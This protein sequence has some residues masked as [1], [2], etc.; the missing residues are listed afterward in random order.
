VFSNH[1]DA[2]N[3]ER[4]LVPHAGERINFSVAITT[5]A[6]ARITDITDNSEDSDV[7]DEDACDVGNVPEEG[8]SDRHAW[9]LHEIE[10]GKRVKASDIA[11]YFAV[12]TKTAERDLGSP[13]DQGKIEFSGSTR[14][15]YYRLVAD[16]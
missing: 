5:I 8:L 3:S 1:S 12:S 6:F 4:L 14:T 16:D 11:E 15:G 13:K 10:K 7:G 2:S 9:I